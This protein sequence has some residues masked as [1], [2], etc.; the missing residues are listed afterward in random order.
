MIIVTQ[1]LESLLKQIKITLTFATM[2]GFGR[3]N[4]W[5]ETRPPWY[6]KGMNETP[7]LGSH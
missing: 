2:V 3:F 4:P 5:T 7:P 1:K 6:K